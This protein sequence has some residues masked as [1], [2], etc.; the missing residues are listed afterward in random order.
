MNPLLERLADLHGIERTYRSETGEWRQVSEGAVRGV[1]GAMGVGTDGEFARTIDS[2]ASARTPDTAPLRPCFLPDWIR[3]RR[4]WGLSC[5]LYGLRSSRNLGMGDFEDLARLAEI[6]AR[7]GADFI[8]I[9]PLHALFL[10]APERISPYSPSH[11][12][13]LN[14]LYIAVDR[15][16]GTTAIANDL[17]S[18]RE[19]ELVAYPAVA[20]L[21]RKAFK[22]AFEAF[23]SD[24]FGRGTPE[25]KAFEAFRSARDP[26][27]AGFA[28]FEALSDHL[29]ERGLGA[30]WTSW[31]EP[32]QDRSSAEVE[33]FAEANDR[34][35]LFHCWLQWVAERQLEDAQSRACAAGMRIGL[36]LDVAV[37]TARDGAA[38]WLDPELVT[39]SARIGS[40]PDMFND[41]GQDWNLAPIS[42]ACLAE[43]GSKPFTDLYDDL[44]RHAGAIRI[45]HV[46]GVRRLWWIPEG[47]MAADGAYVRYPERLLLAALA[48]ASHRYRA[49]VIGEDLGTVPEGF[50]E[51]MAKA[52]VLSYRVVYFEHLPDRSFVPAEDYPASA[53]VCLSTHDL[54]TLQGWWEGTDIELRR[55]LGLLS[56]ETAERRLAERQRDK[57]VFL[58]AI[59]LDAP[60]SDD[61]GRKLVLSAHGFLARTPAW[62]VAVQLEDVL[63]VREQ[64]NLPGTVDEHPNWRRKLPLAIEELSDHPMLND[65]ARLMREERP[66]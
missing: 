39:P 15:L 49:I 9:N 58:K 11:R 38:T 29:T 64:A 10:A 18:L 7:A 35:I 47:H 33:L 23:L 31:P 22:Q 57:K 55:G 56:E 5:Q 36:Y 8:G 59:G 32:F 19:A 65:I 28:L 48:D 34:P 16:E 6:G 24:H 13:F 44:T 66:R 53:L 43:R 27:L 26:E 52:H 37:G 45:D 25:D 46:M 2:A 40:P 63:G 60:S 62:L 30:G 61:L 12:R 41:F 51:A 20:A 42:P 50:R 1:L 54:P 4:V 21:K 17:A 3:E 14:P